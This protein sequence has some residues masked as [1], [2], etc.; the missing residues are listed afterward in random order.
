VAG[1]ADGGGNQGM[2]IITT[3]VAASVAAIGT[4]A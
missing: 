4:L 3:A 2:L 1:A